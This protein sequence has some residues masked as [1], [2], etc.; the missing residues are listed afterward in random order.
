MTALVFPLLTF[1]NQSL[2]SWNCQ[3]YTCMNFAQYLDEYL[4][5]IERPICFMNI[6]IHICIFSTANLFC[7]QILDQQVAHHNIFW[8]DLKALTLP[9][10]QVLGSSCQ[11]WFISQFAVVSSPSPHPPS[12]TRPTLV[13]WT[14]GFGRKQFFRNHRNKVE[15]ERSLVCDENN[16][17]L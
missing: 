6:Y 13:S 11:F 2:A 12:P 5:Y 16:N 4:A 15:L 10:S 3:L 1:P 9:P 17:L 7:I 8:L 14:H